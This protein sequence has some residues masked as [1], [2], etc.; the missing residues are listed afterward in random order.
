MTNLSATEDNQLPEKR[1]NMDIKCNSDRLVAYT[2]HDE[3]RDSLYNGVIKNATVDGSDIPASSNQFGLGLTNDGETRLGAYTVINWFPDMT[4][5][6]SADNLVFIGKRGNSDDWSRTTSGST[7]NG[8][9]VAARLHTL[10]NP[11][12]LT[13]AAFS[14]LKI[15]LSIKGVLRKGEELKITDETNLDGEATISLVYL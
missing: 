1:I 9:D 11:D 4:Y 15:P 8:V 5:S 12:T 6:G 3:R 7:V 2:L 10:G 14:E 13:P